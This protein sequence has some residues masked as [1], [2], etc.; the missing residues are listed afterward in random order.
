MIEMEK[1]IEEIPE[2]KGPETVV[3]GICPACCSLTEFGFQYNAKNPGTR[4]DYEVYT[5]ASC[6]SNVNGYDIR[7]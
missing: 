1:I 6:N 7:Q 3:S 2:D 4:E 5:C